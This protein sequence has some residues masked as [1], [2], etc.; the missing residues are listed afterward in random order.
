MSDRYLTVDVDDCLRR[1][2][3]F[4]TIW[5]DK[6]PMKVHLLC[7]SCSERTGKSTFAAYGNDQGS[8]GQWKVNR[9][10]EKKDDSVEE[11]A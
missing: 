2:H 7:L 9:R 4:G 10:R 5:S 3:R 6:T 11:S 1:N 8:F